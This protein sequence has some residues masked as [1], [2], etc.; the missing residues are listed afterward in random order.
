MTVADTGEE[1]EKKEEE[2]EQ[3]WQE[4]EEEEEPS[5]KVTFGYFTSDK[6]QPRALN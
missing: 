5:V 6:L 1:V 3:D 4:E 2:E